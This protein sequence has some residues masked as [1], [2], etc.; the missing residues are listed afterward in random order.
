V[1]RGDDL[2]DDALGVVHCAHVEEELHRGHRG[3]RGAAR[4]VPGGAGES[5]SRRRRATR[6]AILSGQDRSTL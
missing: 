3:D 2:A 5:L 4:A 6:V 1:D